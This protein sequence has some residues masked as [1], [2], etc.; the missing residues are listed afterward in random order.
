MD[1][2][3][4][5]TEIVGRE[6]I[7][8]EPE[9]LRNFSADQSLEKQRAASYVVRPK[10]TIEVQRVIR[11]SNELK[12]PVVPSSSRI[13]FYGSALPLQGGIVL[14]LT[15]MNRIREIDER[16]RKVGIEPGVTWSQ[17]QTE[18]AKR[19]LMAMIPFLPHP[20][21]SVITSHLEREPNVIP[22]H[23]Y[24]DPMLTMEFVYPNG[25]IMRTGS[26]IVPGATT[27]AVSDGVFPS[28]ARR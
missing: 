26:A 7:S 10:D 13:H 27:T 12:L 22:K 8:D 3:A 18:L 2:K 25:K 11:L 23:E 17:L 6:N 28:R 24:G 1:I 19:H 14:D 21:K 16:N 15:R 4:E 5:L 20:L 9:Q